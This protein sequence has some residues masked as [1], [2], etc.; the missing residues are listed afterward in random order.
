MLSLDK[1][2]DCRKRILGI[3]AMA[4]G[5]LGGGGN[6]DGGGLGAGDNRYAKFVQRIDQFGCQFGRD[7]RGDKGCLFELVDRILDLIDETF[8]A[9]VGV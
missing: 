8:D 4:L 2:A 7:Q 1:P 6:S 3:D 9:A 5:N